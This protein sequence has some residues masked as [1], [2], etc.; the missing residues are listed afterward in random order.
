M[1]RL[2]LF[3]AVSVVL[4]ILFFV[5]STLS[6]TM[7]ASAVTHAAPG[8]APAATNSEPRTKPQQAKALP[9]PST[10]A[11]AGSAPASSLLATSVPLSTEELEILEKHPPEKL[12]E[13]IVEAEEAFLA[14]SDSTRAERRRRYLLVQNL[15]AKLAPEPSRP[16]PP[17]LADGYAEYQRT[18]EAEKEIL[19]QLPAAQREAELQHLKESIVDKAERSIE[20]R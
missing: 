10:R 7:A 9:S 16:M 14:A 18:V 11:E 13:V 19:Q 4:L 15:A 12:L 2:L 20:T 1:R 8:P 6:P 17:A 3:A 5:R